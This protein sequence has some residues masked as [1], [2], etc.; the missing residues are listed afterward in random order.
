MDGA[1]VGSLNNDFLF[2][3]A[4]G[5][6]NFRFAIFDEFDVRQARLEAGLAS[7]ARNSNI[8]NGEVWQKSGPTK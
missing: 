5:A 6:G 3:P 8:G 1:N 7:R 2:V 4:A